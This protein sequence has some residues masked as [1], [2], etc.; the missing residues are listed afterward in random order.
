[1]IKKI[2]YIL[3]CSR[4]F[5]VP[6]SIFS[7]LVVFTY[8]LTQGGNAIFGVLA[9][10]GIVFGQLATN[11]FDDYCDFKD[12]SKKADFVEVTHKT[13]CRYLVDGI[14]SLNQTLGLVIFYLAVACLPFPVLNL[15]VFPLLVIS[16]ISMYNLFYIALCV[17]FH[18]RQRSLRTGIVFCLS[19]CP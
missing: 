9:L 17:F 10:I 1:M 12:I 5:S 11:V 15:N 6:M 19:L 2:C 14:Y 16:N 18:I 8:G 3:E 7:W 4:V 13:K